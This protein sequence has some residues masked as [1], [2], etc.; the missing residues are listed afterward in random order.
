MSKKWNHRTVN[1]VCLFP[2]SLFDLKFPHSNDFYRSFLPNMDEML[3]SIDQ[4]IESPRI[5]GEIVVFSRWK[6]S[7]AIMWYEKQQRQLRRMSVTAL[8]LHDSLGCDECEWPWRWIDVTSGRHNFSF[9]L[10]DTEM[11]TSPTI[12]TNCVTIFLIEMHSFFYFMFSIP[13]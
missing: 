6:W 13:N 3:S 2:F 12:Q 4:W 7:I 1:C 11:K 5:W 10:L 8:R 9:E